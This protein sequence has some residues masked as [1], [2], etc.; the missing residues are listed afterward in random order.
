MQDSGFRCP[1]T[2][3]INIPTFANG[4]RQILMPRHFPVRILGLVEE[5]SSYGKAFRTEDSVHEF[6]HGLR[7]CKPLNAWDVQKI[8][9][10]IPSVVKVIAEAFYLGFVQTR[11]YDREAILFH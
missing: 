2:K 8:S 7:S 11:G 3:S 1:R 4:D 5:H 9:L 10:R 6:A